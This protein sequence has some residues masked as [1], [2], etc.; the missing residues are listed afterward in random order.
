MRNTRMS[1]FM[2]FGNSQTVHDRL[3]LFAERRPFLVILGKIPICLLIVRQAVHGKTCRLLLIS[4][5]TMVNQTRKLKIS[6]SIF[7][8]FRAER[9]NTCG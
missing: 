4:S 6:E 7:V 3:H 1:Q 2:E 9:Y 5:L 8:I